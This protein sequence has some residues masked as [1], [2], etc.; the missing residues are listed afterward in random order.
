VQAGT[1]SRENGSSQQK[2]FLYHT[3][4]LLGV[5]IIVALLIILVQPFHHINLTLTDQL[6]VS[7]SPSSNIVVAGID[8]DALE[9]HGAWAN[10][11]RSLHIRAINNLINAGARVIGFDILFTDNSPDDGLLAAEIESA[12]NVVLPL[13][14]TNHQPSND[15][16]ATYSYILS[17]VPE[18]ERA[19]TNLGHANIL[20][21]ADGVVR[22]LPLVIRDNEGQIY[23]ALS[24]AVLHTLFNAELP[25]EYAREDRMLKL[26]SRSIPVDEGYNY[27]VNYTPDNSSR[28]YLSYRD[29]ISGDFDQSMVENKVV[30]IGMTATGELD[31]WAVPV[32]GGKIPG[33][34]IHAT[35]TDNMLRQQH[36]VEVN[37]GTNLLIMLLLVGIT[38][39]SLPHLGLRWG[40]LVTAAL[41][42]GYL[43]ISFLIF[44]NGYILNILYPLSILPVSY[45]SN[46]FILNGA[47]LIENSRLNQKV[48][49]GYKSTIKA[50]AASI[51]AK[52]HYTRGHSQRVTEFALLGASS[53]P[54][55][56]EE[57]EILEYAGILHDIGKIGIP[58]S[59]LRKPGPLTQEEWEIIRQHPEIGANII[60][61][62][63]FLEE[64]RNLA[65][66]HHERYDGGGYPQGLAGENIPLGSR[67]L[68]VADTFDAM[69]TDRAYRKALTTDDALNE[70]RK[71][72]G[73]QLCPV[74]VEAF[75]SGFEST[76]TWT[77]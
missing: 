13:V 33:V 6:F 77:G 25:Q 11:P 41:F 17:P 53:L 74:A 3:L 47:T 76:Y 65:M 58:D 4:T 73:M 2:Q 52:D 63:P 38:G 20:P 64:A 44:E 14:G 70:L 69:T 29:I 56:S 24:L 54:M 59:I 16:R 12:G 7:R 30:L 27:R 71:V 32:S 26:L 60:E 37:Q 55:S 72:C 15:P 1:T 36:L 57:L 8:D 61:D 46:V 35:T 28:P 21:D 22:R 18:L 9:I 10:W 42:V 23:P 31:K 19:T 50:L 40:G 39:L 43:I 67:L 51:D 66:H 45:I 75:I 48:T 49:E 5:G 68:A 34:Y 62:I